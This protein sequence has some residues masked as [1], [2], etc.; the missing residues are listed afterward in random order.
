[1]NKL[2]DF[3]QRHKI[4]VGIL[5]LMVILGLVLLFVSLKLI[6]SATLD[7]LVVPTDAEIMVDGE[8]YDNGLYEHLAV[9]KKHVIIRKD[10]FYEKEFDIELKRDEVTRL[11]AHLDGNQEWYEELKDENTLYLLDIIYEYEGQIKKDDL[12]E[13]YPIMSEL[14]IVYEK[15]SN[16]YTQY[17]SFRI[18]GGKYDNCDEEFCLK[19]TDI[20][21]E[22]YE[23]ALNLI[24]DRGY[25]PDNYKI[26]YD[27]TSKKGHAG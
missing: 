9:G 1:M 26:I 22:N 13:K 15:Y 19:I 5:V 16:N 21:G 8:K 11:Y 20:S 17:I 24:K 27:D 7:V 4:T 12:L 10:G 18:D 3:I 2:I 23:R 25:N 6:F 14:P